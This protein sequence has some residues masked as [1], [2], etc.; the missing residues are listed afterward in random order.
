MPGRNFTSENGYRY[1]FNGKEKDDEVKGNGNSLDF[2]GRIYD[3][4]LG[5]W[6]SIDK[7]AS[8][9]PHISPY[10]F[11]KDNPLYFIDPDGQEVKISGADAQT[12]AT[13]LQTKTSLKLHYDVKTQMLTCTGKPKTALDQKLFDAIKVT[14]SVFVSVYLHPQ[15]ICCL[16][17][18][19]SY[20]NIIIRHLPYYCS[21]NC[22]NNLIYILTVMVCTLHYSSDILI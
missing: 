9:Y 19:G 6:L 17:C 15:N 3:S 2:G 1:G 21:C 10:L 14:E 11:V 8:Q 18:I 13:A 4:R 12:A 16:T 7:L 20:F 22:Q 5:R